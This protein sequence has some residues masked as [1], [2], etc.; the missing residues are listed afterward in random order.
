M[1]TH[2]AEV[3]HSD[4]FTLMHSGESIRNSMVHSWA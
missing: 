3:C 1:K 2:A 4:E